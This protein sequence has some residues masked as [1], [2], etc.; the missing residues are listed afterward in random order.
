MVGGTIS[1]DVKRRESLYLLRGFVGKNKYEDTHKGFSTWRVLNT[2]SL[3]N[4]RVPQ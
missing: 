1:S 2:R 4:T 3:I